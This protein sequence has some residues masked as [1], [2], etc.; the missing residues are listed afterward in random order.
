MNTDLSN[1][2][3]SNNEEDDDYIPEEKE[4]NPNYI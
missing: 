1:I 4:G 2:V 3:D